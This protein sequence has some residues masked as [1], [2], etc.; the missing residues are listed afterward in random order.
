MDGTTLTQRRERLGLTRPKLAAAVGVDHAT[1]WRIETQ[2]QKPT[3][4]MARALED[5]LSRLERE[6]AAIAS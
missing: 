2:G 1:I 4:L 5:T 3:R 6:Q